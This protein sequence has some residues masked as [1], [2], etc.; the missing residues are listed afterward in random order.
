MFELTIKVGH[1]TS[2]MLREQCSKRNAHEPLTFPP[3]PKHT[4]TASTTATSHNN[5]P[6]RNEL[7]ADDCGENPQR[8]QTLSRFHKTPI[9]LE[10]SLKCS[11]QCIAHKTH[12]HTVTTQ[13]HHSASP[14]SMRCCYN[15]DIYSAVVTF[16]QNSPTK[17]RVCWTGSSFVVQSVSLHRINNN[18][19]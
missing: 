11:S 19:R 10:C 6:P 15:N 3:P 2:D 16:I 5:P 12:P 1:K 9:E 8:P 17:L 7:K 14:A 18:W 13:S 4:S